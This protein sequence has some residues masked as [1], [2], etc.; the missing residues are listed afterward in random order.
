[1][2]SF[3]IGGKMTKKDLICVL[4]IMLYISLSMVSAEVVYQESINPVGTLSVE[5]I[6]QSLVTNL[7]LNQ[8]DITYL[9]TEE[10]GAGTLYALATPDA[11]YYVNSKTGHIDRAIFL[12]AD[13]IGKVGIGWDEA[14]KM[15]RSYADTYYTDFSVLNTSL[16]SKYLN[17]MNEIPVY[18]FTWYE[19]KNGVRTPNYFDVTLSAVNGQIIGFNSDNVPIQVTNLKPSITKEQAEKLARQKWASVNLS[20]L[21]SVLA[22]NYIEPGKQALVWEVHGEGK[23]D[24]GVT[25]VGFGD[26]LLVDAINGTILPFYI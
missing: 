10:K 18:F 20:S 12:G 15:A 4:G 24:A 17:D 2:W 1:M 5:A 23:E 21:T 8:S 25:T 22:I 13:A 11:D 9:R 16:Y 19:F 7:H 26:V 3:I 14:E 6:S